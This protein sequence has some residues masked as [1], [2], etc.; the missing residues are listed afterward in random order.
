MTTF[1][2]PDLGEGLQEAE[3]LNWHVSA[4]DHVSADQPLVSVE[5][6]KAVIEIPA[7]ASGQILKL[8]AEPGDIVQ[9][10]APLL[11]Y[12]TGQA[13]DTGAI[14]GELEKGETAPSAEGAQR[15]PSAAAGEQPATARPSVAPAVRRL[16]AD[17]GVDLRTVEASGEHGEITAA[18]VRN[19]G[20]T[21]TGRLKGVSEELRGVRRAM[22]IRMHEAGR[23]IV[24]ASLHDEADLAAWKDMDQLLRRA[25]MALVH[26]TKAE[27]SLNAWYD[28]AGQT[29]TLFDVVNIGIAVDTPD[30]LI[31]PVLQDAAAIPSHLLQEKL[32][33]LINGARN[34]T[35]QP[36]ELRGAT[37]TLSNYGALGGRY[38]NLV[39]VPPQV[40]IL[41]I[42]R[43]SGAPPRLPLSLTMDHRVVSGGEA[44]RFLS[45]FIA[46]IER[47]DQER[48]DG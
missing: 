38:A 17:L 46:D 28:R 19:A 9:V 26:A 36:D 48:H 40:A 24:P 37:I 43:A 12:G 25:L 6:D 20:A 39:V 13:T 1:C 21:E 5:T 16:A 2:L 23:E 29:R 18:D 15:R 44:A 47:P 4:G 11:E 8:F 45:A 3:I 32:D 27:P 22:A 35:I 10:G 33:D 30:G 14:V 41:G 31:V 34:R 7:P 42:G